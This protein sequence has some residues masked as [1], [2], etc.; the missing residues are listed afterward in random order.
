MKINFVGSF[1]TGYVGETAD[2]T[3]LANELEQLGHEVNRIPRDIWKAFADGADHWPGVTDHLKAD[4]NIVAK[5]PHFNSEDYINILRHRSEAPVFYWVWDYMWDQGI[6]E[7][8]MNMVKAADLYLSNEAGIFDKY[9][10]DTKA[11]Y[12]PFDVSDQAIDKVEAEKKIRVAFF[13]TW[14]GQGDRIA[15][16]TEIN[17]T[18]DITVFSWNHEEWKSRGFEAYPAVWGKEFAQKVAESKIILGFNVNDYCWGYWSNRVGKV[19]T[20]GGFLLQRYVP[21]MEL[22]LRDGAEYFSSIEEANRKITF[23]LEHNN[24]RQKIA[25]RGYEIG[26]DKFTSKARVKELSILIERFL[27]GGFNGP[28]E[29]VV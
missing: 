18:H 16:L 13:G 12:F 29:A 3:H 27:K 17:K 20:T 6:P 11:H 26:R 28:N 15:W 10:K 1:T 8:H 24:L 23:Y 2:E 14:L 19:L 22:F 5:W 25:D 21:G 7:W 4:I 9:Y